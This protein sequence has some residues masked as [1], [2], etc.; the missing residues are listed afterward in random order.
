MYQ[1]EQSP[2]AP[3]ELGGAALLNAEVSETEAEAQLVG[4]E[5]QVPD[6]TQPDPLLL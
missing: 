3:T 4:M 5:V 1:A 6:A 2:Q